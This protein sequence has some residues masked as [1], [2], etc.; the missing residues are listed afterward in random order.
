QDCNWFQAMEGGI[1]SS[2]IGFL[3]APLDPNDRAVAEELDKASF[4]VGLAVLTGDRAPRFDVRDTDYGVLI[5]A[6][7]TQPDGRWL[8]RVTQFLLPSTRCRPRTSA[9][10]SC[11]RTSGCRWTTPTSSTG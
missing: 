8:W 7:R 9:R 1:D 5:G 10:R 4:G 2:H 3:H 11:S 6:R